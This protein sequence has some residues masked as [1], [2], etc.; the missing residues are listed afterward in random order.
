MVGETEATA[1][2]DVGSTEEESKN[3]EDDEDASSS[4]LV[5]QQPNQRLGDDADF[6]FGR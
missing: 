4:P 2:S 6:G 3:G 1:S 5:P